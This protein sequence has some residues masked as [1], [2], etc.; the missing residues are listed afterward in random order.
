MPIIKHN[1]ATLYPQYQSYS[2]AIE[3]KGDARLLII[4]G[5]NGF[6]QDGKTKPQ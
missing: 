3:I 6:L 5:F 1:P 4:S 2:H